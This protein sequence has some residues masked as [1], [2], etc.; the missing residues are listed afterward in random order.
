[1]QQWYR[2]PQCGASVAFGIRFCG[3]CGIRLSW[4]TQQQM[5]HQSYQQSQQKHYNNSQET[6]NHKKTGNEAEQIEYLNTLV[7][8]YQNLNPPL[9]SIAKIENNMPPDL[10]ILFQAHSNYQLTL[11][12]IRMFNKAPHKDLQ[13]MAKN[14]QQALL[15]CIKAGEMADKMVDDLRYN[16]QSASRMHF[17]SIVGYINYAKIYDAEF[18]K[19]MN[20]LYK[21]LAP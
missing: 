11:Q 7:S 5:S 19:K 9:S 17:A 20:Q 18:T 14:L 10:E 16:A 2:C 15:M 21:R 8:I 3:N 13:R 1:M 4:P 12:N 6:S